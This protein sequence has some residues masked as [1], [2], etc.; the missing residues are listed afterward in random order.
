MARLSGVAAM[1]ILSKVGKEIAMPDGGTTVR[2]PD[3]TGA[4]LDALSVKTRRTRDAL[5]AEAIADYVAREARIVAMIEEG[6]ADLDAGRVVPHEEVM[7]EA[8]EV[9]AAA[10]A[11]RAPR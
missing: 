2:I 7:R 10:R 11:R 6:I 1:A 8:R 9:I 4:A 3:E 5:A